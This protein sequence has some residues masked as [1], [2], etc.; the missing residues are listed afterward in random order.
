M[1]T[2]WALVSFAFAVIC[3]HSTLAQEC[4]RAPQQFVV[5]RNRQTVE[6]L[7]PGQGLVRTNY[8]LRSGESVLETTEFEGVFELER[9][10]R[11]RRTVNRP[12]SDLA[13][14]FPLRVGKD[15][16]AQFES[17]DAS[18]TVTGKIN[19]RIKR[20]DAFYIG[21]CKYDVLVIDRS[22]GWDG[23]AP[24]FFRT[25]YYAPDLKLIIG[26][27]FKEGKG[28]GPL[29]KYDRIYAMKH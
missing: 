14:L 18:H 17:S 16:T 12:K 27:E 11:G 1:K 3:S 13:R 8:R 19:L 4:P 22:A 6:V 23:A 9:I 28:M 7:F 24:A 21:A 5:E 29:N 10:D 25:D 26:K 2:V 20:K 15:A